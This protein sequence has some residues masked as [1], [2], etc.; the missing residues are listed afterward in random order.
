MK[1]F[2]TIV[3]A[4][5][6]VTCNIALNAQIELLSGL[7]NGTYYHL[8]KDIKKVSSQDLKVTNSQGSVE[9]Y[10]RLINDENL[11][12]TF[13]QYDVLLANEMVNPNIKKHIRV[14]LPLFI[15]EEIHLIT[16]RDSEIEDLDDLRG[17]KVGIGS[18]NQ[19][20]R[21]TAQLIKNRTGTAWQDV[22]INSNKAYDALQKG[23]I[24]AYFYVGG[25]PVSSLMEKKADAN[26][27]LVNIKHKALKN[28]YKKKKIKGVYE[29]NDQKVKTYAV[30]TLLVVNVKDLDNETEKKINKLRS[31]IN[32]NV[33]ELQE[34]GHVK[35]KSVY[36]KEQTINW[37]YYYQR[38]VVE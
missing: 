33:K 21:V 2:I 11:R 30:P 19:G 36:V 16:K 9:N 28:V 18:M 17:K 13:V 14:F 27:K 8:A 12:L 35:W 7:E 22:T 34:T 31:E 5:S 4:I 38:K 10:D 1:K 29:W 15:D 20:T 23:E 26:I 6:F 37:P 3:L 24:D 25:M 32:N